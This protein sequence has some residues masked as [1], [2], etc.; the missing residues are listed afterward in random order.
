ME[1]KQVG[2]IEVASDLD[3]QKREWRLQRVGWL[4]LLLLVLG[5]AGGAF[6][7]GPLASAEAKAADN[8]FQLRYH[9][10]VRHLAPE[11]LEIKINQPVDDTIG[12]W[13]D[14]EFLSRVNVEDMV[15]EPIA[16]STGQGRVT[17]YFAVKAGGQILVEYEPDRIGAQSGSLGVENGA[18]LR[19]R[20]FVYP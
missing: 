17:Y 11:H 15:P 18:S 2:D 6:G 13:F 16:T 3:F 19:I 8:S 12:L 7:R 1:L 14:A 5:G 9:K 20:Q 4:G 10:L